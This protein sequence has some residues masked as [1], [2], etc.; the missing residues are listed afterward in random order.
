MIIID[1]P[2]HD[3]DRQELGGRAARRADRPEHPRGAVPAEPDHGDDAQHDPG[4]GR[5]AADHRHGT[6]LGDGSPSRIRSRPSRFN[7]F[8]R[9]DVP[10]GATG[11]SVTLSCFG[12][13][14]VILTRDQ[15]LALTPATMP[16][17]VSG[18]QVT[19]TGRIAVERR[20]A[21]SSFDLRLRAYW[22]GTTERVDP[23][24]SPILNTAE[25]VVADVDPFVACPPPAG[26]R[27]ACDQAS[28]SIAI[29]EPSFSVTADKSISPSQQKE[30]DF[31]PVTV[32]L[33][34]QP[35]GSARAQTMIMTDD[36]PTFW[37][38]MDFVGADP[39]WQ[40]P[41]P[42]S[43]GAGVLPR[44]WHLHRRDRRSAGCV[45]GTWTCM[46]RLGDLS[47]TAAKAF[48]AAAP[49]TLHGLS[50]QFWTSAELGWLNPVNP[51]RQR[52]VPGR[53]PGRPAHRRT[54][55]DDPQRPGSRA[56]RAGCRRLLDTIQVDGTSAEIAPGVRLTDHETA[57][58]E[59]LNLHLAGIRQRRE[60]ADGRCASRRRDP[61][62]ARVHQHGRTRADGRRLH[63]RAPRWMPPATRS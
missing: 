53:A 54:D 6:R 16:C 17:E 44:R 32:T 25:G 31:S 56:G 20:R 27:W 39:S 57:D 5:H 3:D 36:D 34:G 38:A 37:N 62:H 7:S 4:A 41:V 13:P 11:V 42:V 22:R 40:L 48:L 61:V 50:F 47:I 19:Y 24:D 15:A 63:R 14:A 52:A 1:V 21:S 18:V 46:P 12:A 28:A 59:Y 8:A 45:G 26:A 51:D 43:Q 30:D 10:G 49:S 33:T 60:V 55:P 58:A 29:E 2:A 23:S 9:I 35:G